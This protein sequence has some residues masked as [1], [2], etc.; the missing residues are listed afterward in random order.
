M[1][2]GKLN[3]KH[4]DIYYL[5]ITDVEGIYEA[6]TTIN[7]TVRNDL[8]TRSHIRD[9]IENSDIIYRV[10]HDHSV[11]VIKGRPKEPTVGWVPARF[12]EA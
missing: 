8:N 1:F 11:D 2:E 9:L 5:F 10:Y 7:T 3:D 4:E 6:V 12:I